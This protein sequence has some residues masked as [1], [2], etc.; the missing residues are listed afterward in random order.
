MFAQKIKDAENGCGANLKRKAFDTNVPL[1]CGLE[2]FI[3][4]KTGMGKVYCDNC[5]L[6]IQ[7]LKECSDEIDKKVKE[8]KEVVDLSNNY[9]YDLL[10]RKKIDK[11]IDE[12]F[13]Q[14]TQTNQ[15]NV[16]SLSN[17]KERRQL[18]KTED[19]C[20]CG[21]DREFHG[22]NCIM[23]KCERFKPKGDEK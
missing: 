13:N 2:I 16:K 19:I 3:S 17:C 1:Y 11:A 5:K 15:D 7:T 21:H 20:S 14:S 23:C 8:L 22:E 6:K 9:E 18:D 10:S 4:M 12:I